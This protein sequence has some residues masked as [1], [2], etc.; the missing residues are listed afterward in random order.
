VFFFR[1]K[2]YPEDVSDEL[3]QVVTQYLFFLQV[4]QQILDEEIYCSPEASVLLAS[5][6]VQVKARKRCD[7]LQSCNDV[8]VTTCSME[9]MMLSCTSLASFFTSSYYHHEYNINIRWLQ[10]CG[11]RRLCHGT[12]NTVICSGISWMKPSVVLCGNT[13]WSLIRTCLKTL[14]CFVFPSNCGG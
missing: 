8:C 10:K 9:T 1:A 13:L 2:F 7:V 4:K 12:R 3:V 14:L 11:R 6:A 5:Y